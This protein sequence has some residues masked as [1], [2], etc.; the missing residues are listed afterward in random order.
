MQ[1]EGLRRRAELNN[2]PL[3]SIR[4]VD[5]HC[6]NASGKQSVWHD[7]YN[8]DGVSKLDAMHWQRRRVPF[9]CATVAS[10]ADTLLYR[11]SAGSSHVQ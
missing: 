8:P 11:F 3:A 9:T 10:G 4:Y 7:A 5:M 2:W 1:F 6:H